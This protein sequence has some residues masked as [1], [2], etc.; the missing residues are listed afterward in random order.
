[1]IISP[2]LLNLF[3]PFHIFVISRLIETLQ[4]SASDDDT[5]ARSASR[6]PKSK[7]LTSFPKNNDVIRSADVLL[8]GSLP[9]LRN[10]ISPLP[11]D[12][13]L[14]APKSSLPRW[15]LCSQTYCRKFLSCDL[16]SC[17]IDSLIIFQ[18]YLKYR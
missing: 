10:R 4:L 15:V 18:F 6:S 3:S 2:V 1:M 16:Q 9:I 14:I 7:P 8:E 17:M 11:P 12:P 5:D 13:L